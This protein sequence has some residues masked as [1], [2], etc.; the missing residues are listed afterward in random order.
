[1]KDGGVLSGA[2]G[3]Q[4]LSLFRVFGV[5]HGAGVRR[6]AG[7]DNMVGDVPVAIRKVDLNLAA[8]AFH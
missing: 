7:E 4:H 2:E 6:V 5:Q 3:A 8:E 1:M